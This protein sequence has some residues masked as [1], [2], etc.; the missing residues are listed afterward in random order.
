M[1]AV[2]V[3]RGMEQPLLSPFRYHCMI[4]YTDEPG[5]CDALEQWFLT[6]FETYGDSYIVAR[7]VGTTGNKHLQMYF[8]TTHELT[9][10]EKKHFG[11]DEK[12]RFYWAINWAKYSKSAKSFQKARKSRAE[13][14]SYCLKGKDYKTNWEVEEL[15]QAVQFY[16]DKKDADDTEAESRFKCEEGKLA[17]NLISI[18]AQ[19]GKPQ[20]L[21]DIAKMLWDSS[22]NTPGAFKQE[23]VYAKA[24]W[25]FDHINPKQSKEDFEEWFDTKTSRMYGRL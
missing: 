8:E 14:I 10:T 24:C 7:E 3:P 18:W 17:Q 25:L 11:K 4:N 6:R 15:Q 9:D 1:E 23:L 13:N 21:R 12:R 16:N 22:L 19:K 5:A 20:T 2:E